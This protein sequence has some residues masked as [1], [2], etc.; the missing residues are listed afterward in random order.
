IGSVLLMILGATALIS[1]RKGLDNSIQ[2]LVGGFA[3]AIGVLIFLISFFAWCG[4]VRESAFLLT[5][6][7][8]VLL[9]IFFFQ[10]AL[11]AL[12][13]MKIRNGEGQLNDT[14]RESLNIRFTKGTKDEISDIQQTFE[15]CGTDDYEYW[16]E[17]RGKELP[18]SCCEKYICVHGPYE[19]GC[20]EAIV[21]IV[22]NN[23]RIVGI[24][25]IVFSQIEL[26]GAALITLGTI[27][28]IN[29]NDVNNAIPD[30]Y[31]HFHLIPILTIVVGSIIFLIAFFGCCGAVRNSPCLLTTYAI[32]LLTIFILQITLGVFIFLEVKN[33]KDLN[34]N[35][36]QTIAKIFSNYEKEQEL[37]DFIQQ[38][39][40][41]CG[42]T[43]PDY[44][45]E[46]GKEV[47]KSCCEDESCSKSE[48][49]SSGCQDKFY[50]FLMDSAKIVG[51]TVLALS[52]TEIA[53]AGILAVGIILKLQN[54]EI[55]NFIPD[56]Y[57]LGLPPILLIIIGSII[58]VTSFF[59]CCG[60]IRES[61]CMLTTFAIILLTLLIIQIAI[62]AYAF[63]QVGDTVDLKASVKQVVQKSFIQ[64]NT[65]K[66]AQEE[67]D[68]LQ[69]FLPC[70]G[71][72]N[73]TDWK[74][75]DGKLPTSCCKN[76]NNCTVSSNNV[77]EHGCAIMAYKR[78]KSGLDLLG[79]LAVAIAAIEILTF[80]LY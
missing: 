47:P 32:I 46:N 23:V 42:T 3:V 39:L 61:T 1:E 13:F 16:T 28:K 76:N 21:N 27:Y 26:V 52:A 79:I 55:Q 34:K 4:V 8:A 74:W 30:A 14:V 18:R 56:K 48:Y 25:A 33:E 72:N 80:Y 66:S 24:I 49:Y 44:W 63:L 22:S 12:A 69:T 15:C 68:F 51:I 70:C 38:E 20:I 35:V 29:F 7:A 31:E 9:I 71:V 75:E 6:Y 37:V 78:F 62:G 40:K 73:K 67:F 60:A 54:N 65:S 11:S 45:Q 41:C 43:G 10:L 2:V 77:H 57:H 58:F 64:Y 50:D 53:G 59:G 19:K 17:E 5:L 36:K